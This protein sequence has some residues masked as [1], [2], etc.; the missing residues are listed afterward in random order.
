MLYN[1]I[2]TYVEMLTKKYRRIGN[3]LFGTWIIILMS[4]YCFECSKFACVVW[5]SQNTKQSKVC[6][7]LEFE[8]LS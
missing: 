4:V 3:E 1:V 6:V 5:C 8:Y 2:N 7:C